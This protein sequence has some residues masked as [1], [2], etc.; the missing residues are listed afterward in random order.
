MNF[1]HLKVFQAVAKNLSYSLAAEELFVS[2]PTVSIQVKKL[3]DDLGIDLFEQLGKKIYLTEAGEVLY[4]Y[5]NRIF[6]LAADAETEVRELQGLRRG[7]LVLGA[8]T[9]PGIYMLPSLLG[10]FLEQYPKID[11]SLQVSNSHRVQE[12]ILANQLDC[13][14]V[15]E[16][17]RL[18]PLLVVEPLYEDELQVIVA[19]AHPLAGQGHLLLEELL[20]QRLILRERGSSTREVLE[21]KV[22]GQGRTLKVSLQLDSIEAIKQAV[23][24]NL[25]VSI[26]SKLSVES[27][28]TAGRLAMLRIQD[29]ELVRKINLV[30]HREK[31]LSPIV[32]EFIKH[33]CTRGKL[34]YNQ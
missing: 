33:L 12:Q 28:I 26:V 5:A 8:S 24:A 16:E 1:N 29:L 25:G 23:V 4:A 15:G 2:Q 30:Y 22:L 31:R 32:K 10:T 21:E 7:R 14:I 9:T 27:E 3:E 13:G 34:Y 17:I 18:N 11:Y 19:K 20:E 6:S